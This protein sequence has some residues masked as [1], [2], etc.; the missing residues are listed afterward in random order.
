[1]EQWKDE[2]KKKTVKG[3]LKVTTHHGPGRIDST[4]LAVPALMPALVLRLLTLLQCL[5]TSSDT[6]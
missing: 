1:M 4:S 6:T 3:L 2:V 5:T